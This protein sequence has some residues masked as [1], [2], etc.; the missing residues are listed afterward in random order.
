MKEME[1]GGKERQRI[2]KLGTVKWESEREREGEREKGSEWNVERW[3]D[4]EIQKEV[5]SKRDQSPG[6]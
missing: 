3:V 4:D 6:L 5:E 2:T 1:L